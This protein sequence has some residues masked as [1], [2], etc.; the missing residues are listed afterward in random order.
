MN[1]IGT[2]QLGNFGLIENSHSKT[3][4]LETALRI[5]PLLYDA[6]LDESQWSNALK[7]IAEFCDA[8]RGATAQIFGLNPVRHIAVHKYGFSASDDARYFEFSD[9]E[10]GDPRTSKALQAPNKVMHCRQLVSDDEMR[11]SSIYEKVFW[12]INVEYSLAAQ[13][14]D[15]EEKFCFAL[16]V[17][18]GREQSVFDDTE[19]KRLNLLLP[20]IRRVSEVYIRLLL[21]ADKFKRVER[22]IND[23]KVAVVFADGACKTVYK[24]KAAEALIASNHGLGECNGYITHYDKEVSSELFKSVRDVSVAGVAG[25]RKIVKHVTIPRREQAPLHATLCALTSVDDNDL[26]VF[27]RRGYVAIYIMDP[28]TRYESDGEQLQRVF[29]LTTAESQVLKELV[30]GS[31]INEIAARTGRVAET[32]RGHSKTIMSKL[33]VHRQADLIR[34]VLN[35]QPPIL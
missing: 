19:V 14:M 2:Q 20:H 30:A 13:I 35:V 26:N 25:G 6:V 22:L 18:R 10:N 17:F 33:G 9:M 7:E 1:T 31:S 3:W 23:L 21:A 11:G 12:P 34:L 32:V 29:G 27:L 28:L 5:S 8:K 24:N 16:G 4:E 15:Q